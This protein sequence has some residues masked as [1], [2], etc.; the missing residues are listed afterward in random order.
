MKELTM[1]QRESVDGAFGVPGAVVGAILGGAG[2]LG[3]AAVSGGSVG[4][5]LA[6]VGTGALTGFVTGGVT[7]IGRT[8]LAARVSAVGGVASQAGE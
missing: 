7:S 4:G 6:S 2:Y 3:S 5:F 8:F 1:K